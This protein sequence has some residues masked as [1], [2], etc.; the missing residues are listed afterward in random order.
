[1][2]FPTI[3]TALVATALQISYADGKFL[4]TTITKTSDKTSWRS[5]PF[6]N[7]FTTT[8]YVALFEGDEST[9]SGGITIT[10]TINIHLTYVSS[11]TT[12][13]AAYSP[14]GHIVTDDE[15]SIDSV[16]MAYRASKTQS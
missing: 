13:P 12:S 3:I 16:L 10:K 11:T 1:M 14:L 6:P 8:K 7:A 4:T 9:I 15:T 5:E 2:L